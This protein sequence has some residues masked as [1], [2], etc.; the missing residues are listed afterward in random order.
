MIREI[1]KEDVRQIQR[2]ALAA[3]KFTYKRI[4]S[5]KSIQRYVSSYYSNKSFVRLFRAIERGNEAFFVAVEG[6]EI[7]GYVHAGK[8]RKGW[9]LRRIYLF[10]S[11]IGK[12][13]GKA[14][15]RRIERWL[16]SRKSKAYFVYAHSKNPIGLKFYVKNGFVR[17]K[18]LDESPTSW[19][20]E[21]KI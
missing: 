21:K 6:A 12:G 7:I 17:V 14:L 3:W 11:Y 20:L 1:Q 16:R 19:C 4:Y 2:I 13:I 9:E 10:P 8:H 15:L 5:P 18:E